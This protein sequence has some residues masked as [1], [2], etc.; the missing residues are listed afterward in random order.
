MSDDPTP[1]T[2]DVLPL[3]APLTVVAILH[4]RCGCERTVEIPATL[5]ETVTMELAPMYKDAAME[6]RVFYLKASGS[7]PK[8]TGP[9]YLYVE[10]PSKPKSL[11]T[12]PGSPRPRTRR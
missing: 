1:V 4:T 12:V 6:E 5:P 2:G 11:I 8:V 9:I 3:A 7:H 10:G